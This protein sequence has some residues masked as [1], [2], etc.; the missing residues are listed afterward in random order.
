MT[1]TPLIAEMARAIGETRRP[2]LAVVLGVGLA[3]FAA[4]PADALPS[5]AAQTGQPCTGC[6]VGG[7][8]PQLTPFGRA[9]KIGGY[10]QSGGEG[11]RGQLPVSAMAFGSFTHTDSNQPSN[12]APGYGNNNN[13]NLDQVSGFIAGG[14]GEHSGAL[15]QITSNNNANTIHLDNTDIRPYTTLFNVLDDKDLRVGL[16]LNNTPTVQDPYNTTFAWGF[17]FVASA[18]APT[19]AAQPVLAGAFAGNSIGATAYLWFDK[20]LY[21]EAGGYNTMNRYVLGRT[22]DNL[23]IGSTA[24]TAPYVRAAYEWDWNDQA[25]HVGFIYFST[26]VNPSLN[27]TRS[28][29]SPFGHDYYADYAFDASY[30]YLGSGKHVAMV[31]GIYTHES[32][33]LAGTTAN[34]N[35]TNGTAFVSRYHLDQVRM[36]TSYWFENTYGATFGWQRTWGP[37]NPVLFAPNAV[38]GSNN[39]KPDSNAFILE[40]DWVPFGHEDSWLAPN[41]NLK[42]GVQYVIYT[43]FNGGGTNYDGFGRN[44]NANNTLFLFAWL[45]F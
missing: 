7:F 22:G 23:S 4:R 13:F 20:H 45:A 10:T 14:F 2:A 44:A 15:V 3:V 18:L 40:A 35:N 38:T 8:G 39:S 26:G 30:Q 16:T 27:D 1:K 43:L 12:S 25:A 37:T 34:N 29:T 6:H 17:P 11:W 32:Q 41:A 28:A 19:P 31:Q 5:Y 33:N 9:F 42:L 24:G 21:L 36:N